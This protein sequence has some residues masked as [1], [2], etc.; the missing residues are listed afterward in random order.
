MR[1]LVVTVGLCAAAFALVA[2]T[3]EAAKTSEKEGRKFSRLYVKKDY[4][5]PNFGWEIKHCWRIPVGP[6]GG[7]GLYDYYPGGVVC[8]FV[9]TENTGYEELPCYVLGVAVKEKK[10]HI[11][12]RLVDYPAPGLNRW[13]GDPEFCDLGPGAPVMPP[14]PKWGITGNPLRLTSTFATPAGSGLSERA[15]C[16]K[17]VDGV[18]RTIGVA[19]GAASRRN[20]SC[21]KAKRIVK[22]YILH[23]ELPG[24]WKCTNLHSFGKCADEGLPYSIG[25]NLNRQPFFNY[26]PG[27]RA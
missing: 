3:A 24:D 18:L 11:E 25:E 17:R 20:V 12:A 1:R 6:R 9:S 10:R 2:S 15:P 16:E 27:Q 19:G 5:G 26:A 8:M 13:T 7:V 23:K 22:R 21:R 14:P 4:R